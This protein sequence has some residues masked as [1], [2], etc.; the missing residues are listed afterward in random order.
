[1]DVGASKLA[2]LRESVTRAN[3]ANVT[4]IEGAT[5][6]I[7]L[8]PLCCDAIVG[9]APEGLS[10]SGVD[11]AEL[12][13]RCTDVPGLRPFDDARA[14]P[15]QGR[16]AGAVPACDRDSTSG[17]FVNPPTLTTR[18]NGTLTD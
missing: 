17:R 5:D 13:V 2:S 7:N 12:R 4:V 6:S 15:E 11:A 16:W 10:M 18:R 1:M 3:L 9:G 8:P 14:H